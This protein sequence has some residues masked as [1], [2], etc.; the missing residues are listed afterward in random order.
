ME[1]KINDTADSKFKAGY[2]RHSEKASWKQAFMGIVQKM[3]V[4]YHKAYAAG[5]GHWPMCISAEKYLYEGIEYSAEKKEYDIFFDYSVSWHSI[6][7][8]ADFMWILCEKK[9][10]V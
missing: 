1:Q 4:Q 3:A 2:Y 6:Y 5:Q 10:R 7:L 9:A 8:P